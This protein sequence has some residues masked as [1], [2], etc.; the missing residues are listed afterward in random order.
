MGSEPRTYLLNCTVDPVKRDQL[1]KLR[2]SHL[3]FIIS[4][5]DE[6]K[7]AGVV[8]PADKPPMG[9]LIILRAD[10]LAAA[11]AKA[12]AD[13]YACTYSNI[14]VLEFQQRIPEQYQDQLADILGA[15]NASASGAPIEEIV[16]R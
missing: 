4:N 7:Y 11:R 12:R 5:L 1:A 3:A 6:I 8:G 16:S 15:L 13:P 14:S 10:S 2:A 9:I